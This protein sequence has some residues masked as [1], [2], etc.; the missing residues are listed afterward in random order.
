M[1]EKIRRDAV[2]LLLGWLSAAVDVVAHG[3]DGAGP[4]V[5]AVVVARKRAALRRNVAREHVVRDRLRITTSR[6]E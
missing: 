5:E 4:E 1:G 6:L 3:R 2:L